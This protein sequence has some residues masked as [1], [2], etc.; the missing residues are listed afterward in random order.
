MYFFILNYF[1]F[2]KYFMR[3]VLKSHFNQLCRWVISSIRFGFVCFRWE[4]T[5]NYTNPQTWECEGKNQ[6]FPNRSSASSASS[7]LFFTHCHVRHIQDIPIQNASRF[8]LRI[9]EKEKERKK[10][11]KNCTSVV[12]GFFP[13]GSWREFLQI[14]CGRKSNIFQKKWCDTELH[15]IQLIPLNDV[16]LVPSTR[17]AN[18]NDFKIIDYW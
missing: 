8:V 12:P 10:K 13:V 17:L 16:I 15:Y 5:T 6:P 1:Y 7:A 18:K 14:R 2:I 9:K 11:R 4:N 3:D